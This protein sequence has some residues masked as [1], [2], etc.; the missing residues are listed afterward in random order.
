M[1]PAPKATTPATMLTRAAAPTA[2][3]TVVATLRVRGLLASF[4]AGYPYATAPYR[5]MA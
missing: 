3:R 2:Y 5:N 4:E 1:G